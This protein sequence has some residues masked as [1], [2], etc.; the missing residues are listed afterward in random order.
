MLAAT[1]ENRKLQRRPG[2]GAAGVF[3]LVIIL[4]VG[5]E[6]MQWPIRSRLMDA[7]DPVAGIAGVIIGLIIASLIGAPAINTHHQPPTP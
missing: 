4:V 5:T 1:W 2:S 3:L 6:I 7:T